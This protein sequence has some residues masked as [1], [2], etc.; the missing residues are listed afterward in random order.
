MLAE[1]PGC[2]GARCSIRPADSACLTFR[3]SSLQTPA[4]WPHN[5]KK[6]AERT[7]QLNIKDLTLVIDAVFA[8]VRSNAARIEKLRSMLSPQFKSGSCSL[9]TRAVFDAYF[10]FLLDDACRTGTA[11][12]ASGANL[13]NAN[14]SSE[15]SEPLKESPRVIVSGNHIQALGLP[16]L[17][18]SPTSNVHRP[19]P[20]HQAVPEFTKQELCVPLTGQEMEAIDVGPLP[21]RRTSI[22]VA[23]L[24][25]LSSKEGATSA[26]WSA[27]GVFTA[28]EYVERD[29]RRKRARTDVVCP[30]PDWSSYSAP[31]A[32]PIL[33]GPYN[34]SQVGA[35][36]KDADESRWPKTV[37]TGATN[38]LAVEAERPSAI[39]AESGDA[40]IEQCAE[41]VTE[42]L[43][44]LAEAERAPGCMWMLFGG[45][46]TK[47]SGTERNGNGTERSG[48]NRNGKRMW[49]SP[50]LAPVMEAL[51]EGLEVAISRSVIASQIKPLLIRSRQFCF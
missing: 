3:I 25:R 43:Q 11:V 47:R 39:K 6:Y 1:V 51:V 49:C 18:A 7:Q 23:S 14:G 48:M 40:S 17:Q 22:E 42:A 32:A 21:A 30:G 24:P 27:P 19:L 50:N 45:N 41:R 12:A 10:D 46:G 38:T 13:A 15:T 2:C 37:E 33:L 26:I 5:P 31:S 20:I 16:A 34:P 4:W 35:S 9:G 28:Q 29:E 36:V 8:Q 44:Q